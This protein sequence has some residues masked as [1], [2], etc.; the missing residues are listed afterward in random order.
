VISRNIKDLSPDKTREIT[1]RDTLRNMLY[2]LLK[3]QSILLHAVFFYDIIIVGRCGHLLHRT[4]IQLM[5]V[6]KIPL[7]GNWF[8][9]F[10][11]IL[12]VP[13]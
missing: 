6:M 9:T 12:V 5:A 4:A 13:V 7:A 3:I 8:A 11:C 2:I 10:I 1:R